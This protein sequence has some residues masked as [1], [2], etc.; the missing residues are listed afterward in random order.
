MTARRF[1]RAYR[2]RGQVGERE[3]SFARAYHYFLYGGELS[4]FGALVVNGDA[5]WRHSL[6][7]DEVMIHIAIFFEW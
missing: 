2:Y 6:G 7:R 4:L 3:S 5:S 1:R